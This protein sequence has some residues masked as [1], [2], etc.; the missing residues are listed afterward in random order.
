MHLV[1][2]VFERFVALYGAQKFKVMFEH[3]DNAIM[4]AKEAWNNFLQSCKPDV[5]RK[6]MDALPHQKREWPPNLSEF[7][8][9]CKD[10][11]RVE[12]RTY[13]ALPAPK[14]QTDV[15]RTALANMKAMLEAKRA[16]VSPN[17]KP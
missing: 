8:G 17:T 6:V 10:F 4:P 9:M 3:D 11:D 12:H 5:L 14:V 13:D 15:G 1:D 7:I 2:R 16:R